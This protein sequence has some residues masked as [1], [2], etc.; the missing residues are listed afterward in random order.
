M[1]KQGNAWAIVTLA[2]RD[3][4][5]EVLF[6]PADLPARRR[7]LVEDSV[8]SVQGRIND[9]DGAI[10]IFGHE[11]QVLDVSPPSTP[12]RPV[13]LTLPYHRVNGTPSRNSSGSWR[14]TR[15]EPGI[16]Q[17]TRNPQNH[18]L[19]PPSHGQR[20]DHRLRHQRHL[21]PGCVAGHGV[22]VQRSRVG[23]WAGGDEWWAGE[24]GTFLLAKAARTMCWGGPP[25]PPSSPS[26]ATWEEARCESGAVPPL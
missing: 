7:A 1:T 15:R 6:F 22:N 25:G 9:R 16:H 8:V 12:A 14:R 13:L 20:H 26:T 24:P 17:R 2:D 18:H 21:R 11:L 3:G 23:G 19:R 4:A 5:I 10:N